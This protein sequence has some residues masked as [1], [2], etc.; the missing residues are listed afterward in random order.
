M[1]T[2]LLIVAI[3]LMIAGLGVRFYGMAQLA[4]KKLS[5]EERMNRYKKI[6]P[7]SYLLLLP[8]I[9]IVVYL[10]VIN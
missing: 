2:V 1:D 7:I 9:A 5:D 3:I 10:L 8:T 6:V 4:N